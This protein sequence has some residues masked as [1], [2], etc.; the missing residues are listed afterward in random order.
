L[1]D[2]IGS[3]SFQGVGPWSESV[4]RELSYPARSVD[5]VEAERP[6]IRY[7][8]GLIAI[9][10]LM[11]ALFLGLSPSIASSCP[12]RAGRELFVATTLAARCE[13][14]VPVSQ[15]IRAWCLVVFST[16]LFVFFVP[17]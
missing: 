12:R 9:N 6:P 1:R 2:H 8:G 14:N 10:A 11:V 4:Y 17:S 7:R 15:G 5:L 16:F 3:A 13:F